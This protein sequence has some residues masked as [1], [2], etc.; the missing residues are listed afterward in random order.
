MGPPVT[1]AAI[2]PWI[3]IVNQFLY[4]PNSFKP[5]RD[6]W[7]FEKRIGLDDSVQIFQLQITIEVKINPHIFKLVQVN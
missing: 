6:V 2:A 3:S 7:R 5:V 4:H 1:G